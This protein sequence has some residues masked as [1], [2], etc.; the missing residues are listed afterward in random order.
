MDHPLV[1]EF[2][3]S[4]IRICRRVAE[5]CYTGGARAF[6]LAVSGDAGWQVFSDLLPLLRID[7]PDMA[8]GVAGLTDA[9][10]A[11][12]YIQ[13]GAD[14]IISPLVDE[15]MARVCNRRKVAW[16]PGAA[17]ARE[18]GMAE[19]LGAELVLMPAG[20]V[21]GPPALASIRSSSPWTRIMVSGAIEPD[22][23]HLLPWFQAGAA[24]AVLGSGLFSGRLE[25]ATG[26]DEISLILRDC[27]GICAAYR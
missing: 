2:F 12:L 20:Q 16:I 1:P 4:D 18:T 25:G 14:F 10:S 11:S 19:E 6:S 9:A 15:D 17:T 13:A 24:G 8:T 22:A 5:A 7:F 23:G 26:F 27:F 3:H 21:P